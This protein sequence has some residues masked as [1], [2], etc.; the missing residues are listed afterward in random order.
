MK[1]TTRESEAF[2]SA[3]EWLLKQYNIKIKEQQSA[4]TLHGGGTY[5]RFYKLRSGSIQVYESDVNAMTAAYPEFRQRYEHYMQPGV[6]ERLNDG[7]SA[8]LESVIQKIEALAAR[9]ETSEINTYK[10]LV[11]SLE[12][13]IEIQNRYIKKLEQNE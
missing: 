6:L 2:K 12:Q 11:S 7:S 4:Y 1:R 8:I 9:G 10:K 13:Q 3:S 5:D